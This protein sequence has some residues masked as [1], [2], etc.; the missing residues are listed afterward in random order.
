[1]NAFRLFSALSAT[2]TTR[3]VFINSA[4]AFVRKR[5]FDGLDLDWEYPVAG[6][7]ANYA[8][9]LREMRVAMEQEAQSS[10]KVQLL[11]TAAVAADEVKIQAG[12]DVPAMAGYCYTIF[13]SYF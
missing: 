6:D 5:N 10:G 2:P 12:Y 4:I 7:K 8:S 9:L 11:L 13:Y 1:M 3:S